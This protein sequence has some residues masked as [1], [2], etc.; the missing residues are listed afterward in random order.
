MY[1]SIDAVAVR[2]RNRTTGWIVAALASMFVIGG[3]V[4]SAVLANTTPL[5]SPLP[6]S[7]PHSTVLARGSKTDILNG[8]FVLTTSLYQ[9]TDSPVAVIQ[10]YRNLL[11]QYPHQLG[12]FLQ[13]SETILPARAPEALQHVPPIF[14]D[15]VGHDPNS[16]N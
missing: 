14:G 13:H 10:Y 4:Y 2:R 12:K 3:A 5:P 7:P 6:A 11:K 8:N 1:T 15:T 16:A 9:T